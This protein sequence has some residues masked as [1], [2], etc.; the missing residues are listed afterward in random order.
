MITIQNQGQC[1]LAFKVMKFCFRNRNSRVAGRG[2]RGQ[3]PRH[4][5]DWVA[6]ISHNAGLSFQAEQL[7]RIVYA[8]V[9]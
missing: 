7:P 5:A 3:L 1:T 8:I 6:R 2:S 4:I 9:R